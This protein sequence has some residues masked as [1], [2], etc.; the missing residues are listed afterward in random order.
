[1]LSLRGIATPS[2]RISAPFAARQAVK[3]AISSR[4]YAKKDKLPDIKRIPMKLFGCFADF[5]VPPKFLNCPPSSW[6]RLVARRLTAFAMNTY[7]V[8]RIRRDTKQKL[9]FNDWKERTV[10]QYVKINKVFAA[11]SSVKKEQR[12][13]FI[14]EQLNEVAGIAVIQAL[15]QRAKTLPTSSS[16]SWKLLKVVE[17]PKVVSLAPIPDQNDLTAY[18]QIVTKVKTKQELTLK[19]IDGEPKVTERLVTDYLVTTI[20][21]HTDEQLVVGSLFESDHIRKVQPDFD[22]EDFEGLNRFQRVCGDLYRDPPKAIQE[23]KK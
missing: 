19:P 8:V 6:P 9:R 5:Y 21:P 1:M 20:N 13:K 23:A 11:S 2:A 10:E 12:T 18:I 7:G 22:P 15:T 17:N 14:E 3:L 16:L 4:G